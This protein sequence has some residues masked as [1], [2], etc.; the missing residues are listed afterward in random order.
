MLI[1]AAT[2]AAVFAATAPTPAALAPDPQQLPVAGATMVVNVTAAADISHSLITATL[3]EADA[4][5][6]AAGFKFIWQRGANLTTTGLRVVIGGGVSVNDRLMPL[7]WIGVDSG[8]VPTSLLYVSHANAYTFMANSRLTVGSIEGMTI[9]QRETYLARAMGRAL[10]H[11]IGHYLMA[12]REHTNK[13]L[14]TAVHSAA[15]FFSNERRAFAIDAGERRQMA[16]R[17]S[18]IYLASRG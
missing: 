10:A 12:S 11:E 8:G 9:L 4:I 17:F 15:E 16:A 7:A 14:M 3:R 18:S 5:W 2:L 1:A 6:R 13:G